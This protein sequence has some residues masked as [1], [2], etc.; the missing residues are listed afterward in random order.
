MLGSNE[1]AYAPA[2]SVEV[3]PRGANRES[4]LSDLWRKGRDTRK[5]NVVEA[6]VNLGRQ[7]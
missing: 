7:L 5:G 2:C 3:L 1:P 4:E 6:I